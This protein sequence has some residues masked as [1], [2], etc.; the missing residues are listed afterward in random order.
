VDV[1]ANDTSAPDGFEVLTLTAVTQGT[2]GSVAITGGGS[3]VSYTPAAN[4][5]G[6]DS[7]TYTIT[8]EHGGTATATANVTVMPVNDMP[9][10]VKGANQGHAPGTTGAQSFTNWATSISD[11]DA[12]VEQAFTFNVNVTSGA[13]IFSTAPAISSDGMLSYTLSGASGIA[14][15]SATLTD[16]ATAGGAALTTAAQTFMIEVSPLAAWRV[17]HFGSGGN[18]GLAGDLADGDH[19]GIPNLLEYAFDMSP[20]ASSAHQLPQGGMNGSFFEMNFTQPAS[21]SGVTYGAEY[22][23]S[24]APNDW[25]PVTNSATPPLHSYRVPTAT[26]QQVFMR[27]KVTTP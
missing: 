15:V 27:I 21:V 11:G 5:N 23:T 20:A 22:S 4:F 24:L 14:Q 16:D 19:D 17:T 6:S 18:A 8:D 10:F 7:F 13:S 1:L 12:G 2:N 3:S 25:H 26:G 9:S